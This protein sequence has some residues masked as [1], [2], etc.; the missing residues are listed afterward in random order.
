MALVDHRSRLPA[1]SSPTIPTS[2][3]DKTP[4]SRSMTTDATA[5]PG[6]TR[7]RARA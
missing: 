4:S 3:I 2:T 6:A 1:S 7:R 5:T